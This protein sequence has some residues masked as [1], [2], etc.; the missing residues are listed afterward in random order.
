LAQ[1]SESNLGGALIVAAIVIGLSIVGGSFMLKSAQDENS[2]KL[3]SVLGEM[4]AL[5]GMLAGAP[6]AAPPRRAAARPASP[7]PQ[8]VYKVDIGGAPTLGP[9]TAKVKIVEWSD[10]QCP[11]CGRVGPTLEQVRKEY[12]DQVQ[13]AF[14]H[15]PLSFHDKAPAAH[16]AA[17]AA[18]EQGKFWEFHDKLF[19]NQRQLDEATYLAYAGEFG[20]DIE[21]FKKDMKSA[22]TQKRVASD[23]AQAG[24]LGVTGTP[25]FYINGRFLSGAQPFAS[26]K[27][28][29]DE[30]LAKD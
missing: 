29:I 16:A 12:G 6:A 8:K 9:K 18:G 3:A 23:I 28:V 30:E 22:Q 14:K 24:K 20:L 15:M 7:D 10:F 26:F 13:L 21:K 5:S 11:F 25:A 2:Q 17:V 4:Q 1:N 27:R 19:A